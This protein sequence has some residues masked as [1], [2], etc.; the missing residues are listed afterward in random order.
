MRG[1]GG[2]V[3]VVGVAEVG[4]VDG[5]GVGCGGGG[6]GG[7]PEGVGLGGW[8]LVWLWLSGERDGGTDVV[9]D[10]DWEGGEHCCWKVDWM[11]AVLCVFIVVGQCVRCL[12]VWTH[13]YEVIYKV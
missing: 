4:V 6:G 11:C 10:D 9:G 5:G 13:K 2:G 3:V 8:V 1:W 7:V 12:W